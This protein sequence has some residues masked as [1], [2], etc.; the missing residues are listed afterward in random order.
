MLAW[1]LGID[2]DT[3]LGISI[4]NLSTT[5]VDHVAGTG[6]GGDWRLVYLNVRPA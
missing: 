4:E 6:L 5:R 1:S 3:A 2:P